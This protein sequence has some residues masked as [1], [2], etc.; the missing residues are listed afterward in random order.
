[1]HSDWVL[2]YFANH[3]NISKHVAPTANQWINSS[4]H[5]RIEAYKGSQIYDKPT[6]I[7]NNEG[8]NCDP[9]WMED[10]T[11]RWKLKVPERF[12]SDP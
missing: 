1:M 12:K 7:C 11:R 9:Q 6:G 2:G 8:A 4:P 5:A 10:E 3:Y